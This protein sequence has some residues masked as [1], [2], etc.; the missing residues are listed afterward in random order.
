MATSPINR[1]P[2]GLL[3]LF[4]IKQMGEY[5][6]ELAGQVSLITDIIP[7]LLSAGATY[8]GETITA[9]NSDT[10]GVYNLGPEL[11]VPDNEVW[12]MERFALNATMA[13]DQYLRGA[14]VSSWSV[15]G[16]TV[17]AAFVGEVI[18]VDGANPRATSRFFRCSND[19]GPFVLAPG[20]SARFMLMEGNRG[21]SGLI[22]LRAHWRALRLLQ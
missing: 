1:L 13:A 20:N 9:F 8:T 17:A 5:P 19:W 18:A 3:S 12:I 7:L 22:N 14:V 6:R 16:G 11:L 15:L 10:P 4:D 2:L 21:A